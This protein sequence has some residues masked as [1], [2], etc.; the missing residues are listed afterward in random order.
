MPLAWRTAPKAALSSPLVALV[1]AATALLTCFLA[2]ATPLHTSASAGAA[3]A[4][5]AESV[6]EDQYGP[7]FNARSLSRSDA[8][9][10]SDTVRARAGE[11]G[12][13]RPMVGMYTPV[14]AAEFDGETF[15]YRLAYR[16]GGVDDL[17][18][19]RGTSAS[20][21]WLGTELA[22]AEN[23]PLGTRGAG[24]ALPPATGVYRDLHLPAPGPWCS[25]RDMT[26]TNRLVDHIET[27]AIVFA[28]DQRAFDRAVRQFD[29]LERAVVSFR[30]PP[31]ATLAEAEDR[32]ARA[33]ALIADV[34]A[35]LQ[36][37]GHAGLVHGSVP[38]QR[39]ID[40]ANRAETN[41]GLSILPLAILA[42]LVGCAGA[43]T[44][45]VQWYQRRHARIRLLSSRGYGPGALGL[46]AL[47][48]LGLPMAFGG[49]AGV[50]LARG[51]LPAY[52]PPGEM[53]PAEFWTAAGYGTGALVLSLALLVSVVAVRAHREFQQGRASGRRARRRLAAY[54]PWELATAAVACAGWLRLAEYGGTSRLGD[55]LPQVDPLALTYPV[56]VVLTVGIV[57]A[58]L[59]FLALRLS[60]RARLWSR[61]AL[62]LA[63]RRLAGARAA[64][65]GVLVIAMLAVGTL[66]VGTGVAEGQRSALEN[67]TGMYVGAESS[68]DVERTVGT[69]ETAL[70]EGARAGTSLIGRFNYTAGEPTVAVVDPDT[71]LDAAWTGTF[72][73]TRIGEVLQRVSAPA[74]GTV[75]AISIGAAGA[76]PPTVTGL[77][78]L[79]VTARLDAFPL[80]GGEPGYVVSRTALTDAQLAE[81]PQWTVLSSGPLQ[82]LTTAFRDAGLVHPNAESRADVLDAL[83]FHVVEWTFS[84]VTLLGIVLAVVAVLILVVA[85]ETRRRQNALAATLLVRMGMRPAALLRSHLAELGAIGGL[86][87]VAGVAS[88]VTVAAVSVR[89]FDP[90][91]WLA[92]VP[93]LPDLTGLI[94]T[95]VG[96]STVVVLL[97]ALLAVRSARTAVPAELLRA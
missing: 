48:E 55:P 57:V 85:V 3:I 50:L 44:L 71:F 90:V 30:L 68:V 21:L 4:G 97:T 87:T 62:Q 27:G 77:P 65:V 6:C 82:E 95:V 41:V 51:L 31:P 40:L 24:G 39:S 14:G 8:Q 43:G 61:P 52:G 91:R 16:D 29:R 80:L 2:T 47:A 45:A 64:V 75:P 46:L 69:G 26:V 15:D 84:F 37:G 42:V 83:P 17:E 81:V 53:D 93:Q 96:V 49:V 89:Q 92:P 19:L 76:A 66:A 20:G 60:H 1:T 38:F 88:G 25:V 7:F 34:E 33:R 28:T 12:F 67:K 74:E 73:D 13:G 94:V 5:R 79:E 70:P 22:D 78:P 56:A 54:L 18:L 9:L 35:D 86:A 23:I 59:T 10:V 32:A 36:A 63:I 72:D 58:R 11:H